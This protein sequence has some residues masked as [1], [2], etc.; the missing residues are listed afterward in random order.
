MGVG[1]ALAGAVVAFVVVVMVA[2]GPGSPSRPAAPEPAAPPTTAAAPA[3]PRTLRIDVS[4]T[5]KDAEIML[6]GVRE[7]RGSLV[8]EIAGD[9]PH[10]LRVSA[11][12]YEAK[13]MSFIDAPPPRAITLV[14][15]PEA[16]RRKPLPV[17]P[18]PGAPAGSP[19]E[20]PAEEKPAAPLDPSPQ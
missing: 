10:M 1:L 9:R 18:A 20:A 5:P 3:A 17:R 8:K 6:D 14:K 2:R 4:V 12:G 7:G 19:S 16:P 15:L 11:P 13:T